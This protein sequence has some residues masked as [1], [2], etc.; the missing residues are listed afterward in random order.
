MQTLIKA[1]DDARGELDDALITARKL[2]EELAATRQTLL[3]LRMR[4]AASR[5]VVTKAE[6]DAQRAVRRATAS[7]CTRLRRV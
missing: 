3:A 5:S 4:H 2:D 6:E 1:R 7:D